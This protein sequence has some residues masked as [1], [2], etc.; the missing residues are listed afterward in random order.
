MRKLQKAGIEI[1]PDVQREMLRAE[2][3]A[4]RTAEAAAE[5]GV[6]FTVVDA[7]TLLVLRSGMSQLQDLAA[8]AAGPG[9]IVIEGEYPDEKFAFKISTKGL[10]PIPA[11]QPPV[12]IEDV[13]RVC[14][15]R[16]LQRYSVEDQ[17]NAPYE[18]YEA[19][20]RQWIKAMRER[21][22]VIKARKKIPQDY[23]TDAQWPE[24]PK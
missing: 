7:E 15:R 3:Q 18:G 4:R 8:Q 1:S 23:D 22:A 14:R 11:P 12:L 6:P 17:L 16:I 10:V 19:E 2:R 21:C 24:A 20:M 5:R 9:E 13:D